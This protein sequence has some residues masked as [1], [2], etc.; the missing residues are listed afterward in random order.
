[1][2]EELLGNVLPPTILATLHANPDKVI[3][4]LEQYLPSDYSNSSPTSPCCTTSN[5]HPAIAGNGSILFADIVSFTVFSGTVTALE[6]VQ[7]LNQMFVFF[8]LLAERHGVDKVKTLGDCYVASAGVLT[9]DPDHAEAICTMGCGMQ[10]AMALLNEHFVHMLPPQ[11]LSIRVGCHCGDVVGGVIGSKKFTFDLW[12]PS[13]ELANQVE[14]EGVAGRV[15]V[16]HD[17]YLLAKKAQV[18]RTAL[19]FEPRTKT[20]MRVTHQDEGPDGVEAP[21]RMYLVGQ[22]CQ[23]PTLPFILLLFYYCYVAATAPAYL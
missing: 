19:R 1:M 11:G 14:A 17:L 16:S 12:G 23:V 22:E 9:P 18:G 10:Q 8:D 4:H 5:K 20:L 2:T 3:T 6:L 7:I 15:N 13:V 21:M